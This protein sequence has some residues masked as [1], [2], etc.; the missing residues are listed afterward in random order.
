VPYQSQAQHR[1]FR[2]AEARGELPQGTSSRWAHHTP[3]GIKGLPQRSG[4][5]RQAGKKRTKTRKRASV[6]PG[7]MAGFSVAQQPFPGQG[8][9]ADLPV[10]STLRTILEGAGLL[11]DANTEQID[12]GQ[13]GGLG[14]AESGPEGAIASRM[15][16][17][18]VS[19]QGVTTN[20]KVEFWNSLRLP[21]LGQL[22]E[23]ETDFPKRGVLN[24]SAPQPSILGQ[25]TLPS[26]TPG[27]ARPSAAVAPAARKT[28]PPQPGMPLVN[29]HP[30]AGWAGGGTGSPSALGPSLFA[31]QLGNGPGTS[32]F[33]NRT[34]GQKVGL[35]LT[36][37]SRLLTGTQSAHGSCTETS[38][39]RDFS[40]KIGCAVPTAPRVSS[41][42]NAVCTPTNAVN[43][44]QVGQLSTAESQSGSRPEVGVKEAASASFRTRQVTYHDPIC[45]HCGEVMGE[46]EFVPDWDHENQKLASN[47]YRHRGP[48]YDKG[49]FELEWPD[50][51]DITG[52]V[53][54]KQASGDQLAYKAWKARGLSD[55]AADYR[56]GVS[57]ELPE[58]IPAG[59]ICP[60]CG[61]RLEY[62]SASQTCN[63]C[64]E[65]YPP[66]KL[67][68]ELRAIKL[69][70]PALPPAAPPA[71]KP[72]LAPAAP[73]AAK[74][75]F[76]QQFVPAA[77]GVL[78]G[79]LGPAG[80]LPTTA[81]P[82]I[83]SSAFE[84]F[85]EIFERYLQ[86]C[87]PAVQYVSTGPGEV[88]Q[89]NRQAAYQRL[90]ARREIPEEKQGAA[91]SPTKAGL[92]LTA[93]SA[94]CL[95]AGFCYQKQKAASQ[96]PPLPVLTVSENEKHAIDPA[97]VW[98][99]I[100]QPKQTLHGGPQPLPGKSSVLGT[101]PKRTWQGPHFPPA[102]LPAP[103]AAP[104]APPG[105]PAAPWY[106]KLFKWSANLPG[107]VQ[108]ANDIKPTVPLPKPTVMLGAK[109]WT[110]GVGA[111]KPPQVQNANKAFKPP[112][113]A[114][115]A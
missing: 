10:G 21:S 87:D 100:S 27:P 17:N 59:E 62:D 74:P 31:S 13:A 36:H 109:Q 73:P 46:K 54:A 29:S 93:L 39:S 113:A 48:C 7:L 43:L 11:K 96:L 20:L 28:P 70:R 95:S 105:A 45:P 88:A 24:A 75:T 51:Q 33:A 32:G 58:D 115:P 69:P 53:L 4:K 38:D 86:G 5:T 2:A 12:V 30:P 97:Q 6:L 78:R 25:T 83:K 107:V 34:Q 37:L 94:A 104:A 15:S 57:L 89:A 40:N 16:K 71:A 49:A 77:T 98:D 102:K 3:G 63:H 111:G 61:E 66:E 108:T 23:A 114:V 99:L 26:H 42:T 110:K 76:Q 44:V 81:R 8:R 65:H 92:S 82:P 52:G 85:G 67:A 60:H 41:G 47:G 103:G 1:Y 79:L 84:Q 22:S 101:P 64:G 14:E 91:M 19:G 55:R 68:Q 56:A 106:Q 35:D 72:G 112:T 9:L 90:Q 50:R 80:L 18:S